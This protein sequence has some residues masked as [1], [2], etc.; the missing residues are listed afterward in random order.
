[1]TPDSATSAFLDALRAAGR[2]PVWELAV[3]EI[4]SSIRASSLQLAAPSTEVHHV[5]HC[6][7]PVPGGE[8]GLRVYTPRPSSEDRLFPIVLHLHG[9]GFVAGDLD[10]HDSIARFH[11]RQAESW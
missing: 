3:E 4:R 5:T 11:C 10:T 8:V 1:M 7:M 9:A 2:K 6:T